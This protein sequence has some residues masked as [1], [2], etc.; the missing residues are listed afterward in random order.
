LWMMVGTFRNVRA[1]DAS[2]VRRPLLLGAVFRF[3]LFAR[4][5]L[6]LGRGGDGA[7]SVLPSET[8]KYPPPFMFVIG[9]LTGDQTWA[10]LVRT[11]MSAGG[12][13]AYDATISSTIIPRTKV[14]YGHHTRGT[15]EEPNRSVHGWRAAQQMD[16]KVLLHVTAVYSCRGA[17]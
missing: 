4:V 16:Q 6:V 10:F 15:S 9:V 8:R 17:G 11:H 12:F 1:K 14:I 5:G 2:S 13:T 3:V 7:R